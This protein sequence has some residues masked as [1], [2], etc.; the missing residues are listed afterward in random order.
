MEDCIFNILFLTVN[1][2]KRFCSWVAFGFTGRDS[3]DISIYEKNWLDY[4]FSLFYTFLLEKAL[5]ILD[6]QIKKTSQ[7]NGLCCKITQRNKR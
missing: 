2:N 5:G 4:S 7:F 1:I 6:N 3:R